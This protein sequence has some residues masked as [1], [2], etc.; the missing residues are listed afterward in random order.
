MKPIQSILLINPDW[1]GINRQKQFQLKRIWPPLD[2]AIAGAMLEQA[3][4]R[5][6]I[7]DNNVNHLTPE[8][9]GRFSRNFDRI[10]VTTSPYDRWQ[11]PALNI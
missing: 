6:R 8:E 10:F 11:C 9:I 1:T 2:L 3:G 7:L 5:V 4:H